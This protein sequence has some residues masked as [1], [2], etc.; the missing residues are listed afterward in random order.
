MLNCKGM[1]KLISD[2]LDRK[3]TLRQKMEL[4]LHIMMCRFCR[5]FRSNAITLKKLLQ[6]QE[7][8]LGKPSLAINNDILSNEAKDKIRIVIQRSQ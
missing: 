6:R 2:S 4:W 3:I 5:R 7:S 1:T 8:E